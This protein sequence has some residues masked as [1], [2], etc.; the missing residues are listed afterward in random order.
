VLNGGHDAA[1]QRFDG[2]VL[3]SMEDFVPLDRRG[4]ETRIRTACSGLRAFAKTA[5]GSTKCCWR[6]IDED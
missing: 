3:P 2:P 6:T 1:T 4:N 5:R